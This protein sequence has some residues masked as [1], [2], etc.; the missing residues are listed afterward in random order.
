MIFPE[1]AGDQN[2]GYLET[3]ICSGDTKI[4]LS[5]HIKTITNRYTYEYGSEHHSFLKFE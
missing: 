3:Y 4:I 5:T 1:F 2:W